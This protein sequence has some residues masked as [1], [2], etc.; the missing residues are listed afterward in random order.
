MQ[1]STILFA[2]S[3]AMA[4]CMRAE[5][6]LSGEFF[7]VEGIELLNRDIQGHLNIS[8]IEECQQLCVDTPK[9]ESFSYLNEPYDGSMP[10]GSCKLKKSAKNY[11]LNAAVDSYVKSP[12]NFLCFGNSDFPGHDFFT[13]KT[14]YNECSSRCNKNKKCNAFSWTINHDADLGQCYLKNLPANATPVAD[15]RGAI[16]CERSD[17]ANLEDI[18]DALEV[19]KCI[20]DCCI[21]V[22]MVTLLLSSFGF[23]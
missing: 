23:A 16:T 19:A 20:S 14:S 21:A 6:A 10:H 18:A 7:K 13:K 3:T 4:S 8:S 5:Q 2:F 11:V 1:P 22:S 9:C 15:N 12:R 17:I